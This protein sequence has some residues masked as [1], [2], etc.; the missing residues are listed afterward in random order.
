MAG[1][2]SLKREFNSAA[3]SIRRER[4]ID[5]T[6]EFVRDEFAYQCG[7]VAGLN[8]RGRWWPAEL[9]PYQD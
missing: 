3:R 7:A 5:V 8:F 1:V 2:H 6:A 4:E 9:A